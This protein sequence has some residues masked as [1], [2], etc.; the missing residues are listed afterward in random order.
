MRKKTLI[1]MSGGVDSSVAAYLMLENGW[2][3]AAATM[4]LFDSPDGQFAGG[5]TCC[6]LS[7]VNDARD[8]SVRLGIPH[9]VLNFKNEFESLVIERFI[10]VYEEGGTPNPCIDCNRFIK[11]KMLLLRAK[12]IEHDVLTTGH[13]A[14]IEKTGGR[15]L[16]KKGIDVKKDQ[17]YVLY[18][19]TQEQLAQTHFPLGSLTKD[20]VRAVALEQGFI[21]AKK[22][23]SQD[24][25]FVPDGDYGAFMERRR[26]APYAEGAIIDKTGRRLGR[27]GGYIRCTIGQRRGL[28]ISGGS[29]PLYVTAK[30]PVENTVTLGPRGELY[31]NT[32]KASGINLIAADSLEKPVK[33]MVKTRYLQK[34]APATVFQEDMNTIRIN[35]DEPQMAV[36]PGQAAVFYDGDVVVGGAEVTAS[37]KERYA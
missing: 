31:C 4:K 6:S 9:Y 29:E 35:F 2:G 28:G 22:R 10:R 19:M 34:E 20:E 1:A 25:C 36:A 17:S 12:Q 7:D 15:F 26:G 11:F 33:L 23:E 8:V 16:L 37:L 5:K 13:Y 30:D 3:C 27:H 18:A 21:N 32:V 24:V 14:R